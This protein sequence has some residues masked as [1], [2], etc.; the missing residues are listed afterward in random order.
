[1]SNIVEGSVR[2]SKRDQVHLLQLAYS[3]VIEAACQLQLAQEMG[4]ISVED[5]K[6]L[7]EYNT[8]LSIKINA[9]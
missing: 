5:H 9:L 4:C 3:S 7:R 2:T 8:T 1:M 6:G